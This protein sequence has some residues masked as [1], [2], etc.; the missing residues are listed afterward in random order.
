MGAATA[1]VAD[2]LAAGA[3]GLA[4]TLP[5]YWPSARLKCSGA[6]SCV[7]TVANGFE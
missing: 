1:L 5:P 4:D 7:C 6:F 3:A 2:D